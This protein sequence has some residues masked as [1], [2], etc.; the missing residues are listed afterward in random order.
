MSTRSMMIPGLILGLCL[1]LS[2]PAQG[3]TR[4]GGAEGA[5]SQLERELIHFR[6]KMFSGLSLYQDRKKLDLGFFGGNY[7]QIFKG[8][9]KALASASKYRTLKITG[10]TIAMT[11]ISV[12]LLDLI[13]LLAKSSVVYGGYY[14]SGVN[15]LYWV[16]L[17]AGG[18]VGIVGALMV[19]MANGYL[20]DA[21]AHYNRALFQRARR[22]WG[23]NFQLRPRGLSGLLSYRF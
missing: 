11:G 17:A 22:R 20:S 18:T 12:L 6:M 1:A 7:R 2:F 8:S 13:L 4:L 23:F 15:T 14:N 3:E 19:P 5:I 16:L 10:F 9:P 21:V